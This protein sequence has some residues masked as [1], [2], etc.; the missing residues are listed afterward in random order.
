MRGFCAKLLNIDTS[1]IRVTPTEIGGGFGGKTVVYLE[2]LA[3]KLSQKTGKPVKMTMTREEVFRASG[4]APGGN[5]K[6]KIG[7]K[8]DGRIVAAECT[9]EMQA[10]AFPGSPVGPACM[11]AYAC[12]D[13]DNVHIVGFDVVSNRPKVAAYRAP[14]APVSAWAV[15]STLD[16]LAL[17]LKMDPIDLRLKNAAKKGTKTAYG[18]TFNTIGMVET[19]EAIRDSEHYRT[20]PKPGYAR[21][22]AAGFW[23]NVGADSSAASHVGEDG[24]VTIIS[25]NPDIGGS[26]SLA[27]TPWQLKSW[28]WI[29]TRVR[30]VIVPIPRRSASTSS[31]AVAALPSPPASRW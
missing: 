10:G 22:V 14:G 2:P 18:V 19:L 6:V 29:T 25:G 24:S 15:E 21:G 1:Q 27:R 4:P 23:F 12:Y 13:I 9:V 8:K 3:I 31:P 28:E 7:A 20:P 16:M 5:V 17:Q 11:C 30:P 26:R